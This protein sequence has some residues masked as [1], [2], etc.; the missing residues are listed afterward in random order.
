LRFGFREATVNDAD[1][2]TDWLCDHAAADAFGD[3]EKLFVIFELRCREL[4]IELPSANRIER[5]VRASINAHDEK[6]YSR[7]YARL[8]P[9]TYTQLDDLLRSNKEAT[10]QVTEEK[11]TNTSA[12]ILK[13]WVREEEL[14]GPMLDYLDRIQLS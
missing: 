2:L 3:F 12:V 1:M 7:I 9:I 4:A 14:I 8:S 13:E 6:F 10:D 11:A 5:I